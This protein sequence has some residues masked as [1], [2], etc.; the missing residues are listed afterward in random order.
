MDW[1][2]KLVWSNKVEVQLLLADIPLIAMGV[3]GLGSAMLLQ[4]SSRLWVLATS[5]RE[6]RTPL[7]QEKC[8][9]IICRNLDPLPSQITVSAS[10]LPAHS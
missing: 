10:A 4:L 9:I 7:L 5:T 8:L 6:S 2:E 1:P 3:L